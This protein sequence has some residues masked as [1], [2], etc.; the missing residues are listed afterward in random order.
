M[1][2]MSFKDWEETKDGNV[3]SGIR[4]K[5]Y[6]DL[7]LQSYDQHHNRTPEEVLIER[8]NKSEIIQFIKKIKEILTDKQFNIL[9]LYAVEGLSYKKIGEKLNITTPTICIYFK[10]IRKKITKYTNKM[11]TYPIY[12]RDL[13]LPPQSTLEIG[14]PKHKVAYPSDYYTCI[15]AGGYFRTTK[16]KQR[17][18]ISKVTCKV[19]EYLGQS[20]NGE[21]VWCTR[22]IDNFGNNNCTRLNQ[23][24]GQ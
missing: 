2:F 15:N 24:K 18:Y 10:N 6:L 8:E 21:K 12:I 11:P 14:S 7:I 5:L 3:K 1:N 23:G 13:L 19:P 4:K 17:K 22:C 9:W 16:K 20:Y